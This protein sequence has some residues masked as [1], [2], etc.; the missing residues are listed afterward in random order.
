MTASA[1]LTVLRKAA[2]E[3]KR[4]NITSRTTPPANQEAPI[5]MAAVA[6]IAPLHPAISHLFLTCT[7]WNPFLRFRAATESELFRKMAPTTVVSWVGQRCLRGK[8]E[9][10]TGC[11]KNARRHVL[12]FVFLDV[13]PH[14]R[15]N[16]LSL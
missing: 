6:L 16:L 8:C 3:E 4:G 12:I 1:G 15:M 9:K 5:Q 11:V 10:V 2:G 7:G 14:K 13:I